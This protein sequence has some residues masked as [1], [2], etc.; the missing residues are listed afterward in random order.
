MPAIAAETEAVIELL[1]QSKRFN[2]QG[3]RRRR[4]E[5]PGEEAAAVAQPT[6]AAFSLIGH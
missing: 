4:S 3:W 5:D 2:V 1:L 6:D